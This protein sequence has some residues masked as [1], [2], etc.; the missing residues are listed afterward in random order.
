MQNIPQLLNN[1]KINIHF[2]IRYWMWTN[3]VLV[4]FVSFIIFSAFN[5]NMQPNHSELMKGMGLRKHHYDLSHSDQTQ[6]L[7][8]CFSLQK[9]WYCFL[10]HRIA[11]IRNFITQIWFFLYAHFKSCSSCRKN[12]FR[13][14]T[15]QRSYT[16]AEK[17]I[18]IYAPKLKN[19]FKMKYNVT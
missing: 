6:V 11:F 3:S 7:F 9:Y 10:T 5:I 14:G 1:R 13:W 8:L 16:E 17:L 4:A 18:K 19:I 2:Y 15:H 12:I